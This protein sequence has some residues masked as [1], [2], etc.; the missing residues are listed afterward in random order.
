MLA[1]INNRLFDMKIEWSEN[2]CVG[3]VMA[4][5]GYPG[6]YKTGFPISGLRRVAPDITVFHAGTKLDTS[7]KVVTNGGRV[8]VVVASGKTIA[9]AREK[10]YNNISL[11]NFEGCHYRKDIALIKEN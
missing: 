10:V 9:E 3:V 6:S 11:I 1:V 4:S 2:A 5:S 8:L 7:G